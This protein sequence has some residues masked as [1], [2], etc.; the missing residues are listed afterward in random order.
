MIKAILISWFWTKFE[1]VKWL[2]DSYKFKN[3]LIQFAWEHLTC[4]KCIGFWLGLALTQ[5]IYL[6]IISSICTAILHKLTQI[7]LKALKHLDH[8]QSMVQV[9]TAIQ[10]KY[11]HVAQAN[12]WKT[13][14]AAVQKEQ[15]F[16]ITS[17]NG[18]SLFNSVFDNRYHEIENYARFISSVSKKKLDYLPAISNAYIKALKHEPK[19]EDEAKGIILHYVKCELL[20]TRTATEKEKIT[21]LE[22]THDIEVIESDNNNIDFHDIVEKAVKE[23]NFIDSIFFEKYMTFKKEGKTILELSTFYGI[24]YPYC[25][26]KISKLKKQI[27]CKI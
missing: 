24:D 22:L 9:L 18:M 1:P 4:P 3:N 17:W 12:R 7:T 27:Q 19:T 2:I 15:F 26:K 20:W 25:K 23:F 8:S 14:R 13:K 21:S 11:T 16:T 5:N 6:A 10:L